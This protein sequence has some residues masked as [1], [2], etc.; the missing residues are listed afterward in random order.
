MQ[1]VQ[2]SHSAVQ[3]DRGH[4][5]LSHHTTD[6]DHPTTDTSTDTYTSYPR[7][8]AAIFIPEELV[9]LRLHHVSTPV[10]HGIVIKTVLIISVY[11]PTG[12]PEDLYQAH[13]DDIATAIMQV[14]AS[15]TISNV[16]LGGDFQCTLGPACAPLVGEYGED[17]TLHTPQLLDFMHRF[18]LHAPHSWTEHV[19]SRRAD[20][21]RHQDRAIDWILVTSELAD[22]QYR[23]SMEF[24]DAS[25][26]RSDHAFVSMQ[27]TRSSV[28]ALPRRQRLQLPVSLHAPLLSMA[29]ALLAGE[30]GRTDWE[31]CDSI[32]DFCHCIHTA[33]SAAAKGLAYIDEGLKCADRWIQ[34]ADTINVHTMACFTP[35]ALFAAVAP[36]TPPNSQTIGDAIRTARRYSK[37]FRK[38]RERHCAR[39]D[40]F[41]KVAAKLRRF[42]RT[43]LRAANTSDIVDYYR[44]LRR[45]RPQQRPAHQTLEG[46]DGRQLQPS[47][48]APTLLRFFRGIY[49]NTN[50]DPDSSADDAANSLPTPTDIAFDL[51]DLRKA[52]QRI[53]SNAAIGPD[54]VHP[55]WLKHLSNPA[56]HQLAHLFTQH[57]NGSKIHQPWRLVHTRFLPKPGRPTLTK[58]RLI[59]QYRIAHKLY[60]SALH[61]RLLQ[62][63]QHALHP[64][65]CGFVPG[66]ILQHLILGANAF[67]QMAALWGI[68]LL[69]AIIDLSRAYASIRHKPAFHALCQHHVPPQW[70]S[71]IITDTANTT[72]DMSA[73]HA[74]VGLIPFAQGFAEGAAHSAIILA[75]VLSS[76]MQHL[77]AR[78]LLQHLAAHLPGDAHQQALQHPPTGWVDDWIFLA[79]TRTELEELINHFARACKP[80]GLQIAI[81]KLQLTT[82]THTNAN[83]FI[84]GTHTVR[85]QPFVTY[86]GSQIQP[87]GQA[88]SMI[89]A[90]IATAN[91]KWHG[92]IHRL[93]LRRPPVHLIR[94][95]HATYHTPSLCWS[96]EAYSLTKRQHKQLRAASNLPL[97]RF[98]TR[99][100]HTPTLHQG[101]VIQATLRHW[102]NTGIIKDYF[103]PLAKARLRVFGSAPQQVTSFL[104]YRGRAWMEQ[105]A[106]DRK[107]PRRATSTHPILLRDFCP[108]PTDSVAALAL[109]EMR[110]LVQ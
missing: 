69:A 107:R 32:D 34:T 95:L 79:H 48:W 68:P 56:L 23:T 40:I 49:S 61:Q 46:P 45:H 38:D 54:L 50:A 90:R 35:A 77:E 75:A 17:S 85:R 39:S 22:M 44:R 36:N 62:H 88:D 98:V 14:R 11:M 2:R 24:I 78:Q 80:Y 86:I 26:K 21:P 59:A 103:V 104:Q 102:R 66:Q 1:E 106:S 52:L 89:Q 110:L 10:M 16:I 19:H 3:I 4:L 60:L 91:A 29:G 13:L 101:L 9:P 97:R 12:I 7:R 6:L 93:D 81:D 109:R 87:D 65:V 63:L 99:R 71:A 67:L 15:F 83:A 53:R 20:N 27:V 5:F 43:T 55:L 28:S 96:L 92:V 74:H 84:H 41:L 47:E 72:M 57:L 37:R 30:Y 94:Q 70:A 31:A 33:A 82:N 76:V 25:L 51:Y 42:L 58:G 18:R 64:S 100:P 8:K 108:R 105:W 73:P